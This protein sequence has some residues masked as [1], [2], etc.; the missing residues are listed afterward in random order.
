MLELYKT[1]HYGLGTVVE[2]K[3]DYDKR[4]VTRQFKPD[5]ITVNGTPTT[6]TPQEIEKFWY[7]E[8]YWL[9]RFGNRQYVVPLLD[10]DYKNRIVTQAYTGPT[11]LEIKKDIH[12]KYPH[13]VDLVVEMYKMF[14]D[15]GVYKRNG[16]L[17][18]IA[19]DGEYIAAFDFKWCEYRPNGI[20][21][22]HKSYDEWLSKIS[23]V[24]PQKLR[25]LDDIV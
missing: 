2:V 10:I 16:S 17:S 11:L 25:E 14:K 12:N 9:E 4:I 24:L 19:C 1:P 21:M 23:P 18:N 15:I 7:N 3:I 13:L 20:E 22:E 8:V 6:K 5:A